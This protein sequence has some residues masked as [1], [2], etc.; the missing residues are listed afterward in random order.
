V[1]W[2]NRGVITTGPL[3]LQDFRVKTLFL[4]F[5]LLLLFF[6]SN[7]KAQERWIGE[8]CGASCSNC[9]VQSTFIVPSGRGISWLCLSGKLWSH[10]VVYG[11]YMLC[12][13]FES[14]RPGESSECAEHRIN[15]ANSTGLA[16]MKWT[17]D[18]ISREVASMEKCHWDQMCKIAHEKIK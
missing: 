15:G 5:F 14:N 9:R 3:V 8:I 11:R 1:H 2:F 16:R 13:S 10:I 7:Q 4:H 6:N 12:I 17:W 18:L